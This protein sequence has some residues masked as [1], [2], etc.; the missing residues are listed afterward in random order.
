MERFASHFAIIWAALL[1]T[2]ILAVAAAL[3]QETSNSKP[4]V[5]DKPMTADQL[6]VY[7]V[8][9]HGWM[10]DGKHS[11]HLSVA[12]TLLDQTEMGVTDCE[13]GLDLEE[14]DANLVHRFR[15]EDLPQLG[16]SKIGLVDPEKQAQ[17]VADNDPGKHIGKGSSIAGAVSN[18][19]RHG[20]VTLS[21]IRFDKSHA[22]AIVW[23]GFTCGSLCG[24]GGD[25]LLE[26]KHGVW[27]IKSHCSNWIS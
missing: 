11:I 13:N 17:E 25:V 5:S 2:L 27:G 15:T 4:K 26:K 1:L 12:T 3:G 16:S 24:N 8:N 19:F 14:L 21:E 20:L 6:A 7:R 10:D 9:L 22:H 18:G 23:Y